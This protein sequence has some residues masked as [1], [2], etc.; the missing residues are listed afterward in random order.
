MA[1]CKF[2]G[3]AAGMFRSEHDECRSLHLNAASK[4][5]QTVVWAFNAPDISTEELRRQV[6]SVA[7]AGFLDVPQCRD[8]IVK[9]W[10][11]AVNTALGEDGLLSDEKSTR[12][13]ALKD[14]LALSDDELDRH[15]AIGRIQKALV[16]E[17]VINGN[18]PDFTRT[19]HLPVNLQKGET[20]VWAYERSEYFEDQ[21]KREY[22]GRSKGV[23][24]Q[25]MKGVR[26]RMGAYK[27]H[28]VD[29]TQRVHVDTGVTVITDRNIYF[30][31]PSKSVRVPYAKIV[32]FITFDDGIGIIRDAQTAKPQMFVTGDGEFTCNLVTNLAQ[33]Q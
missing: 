19:H 32:S 4:I 26:Y 29:K 21:I 31:G 23:S 7:E 24:F 13:M 18:I 5:S 2:C 6:G 14:S 27:G 25:I 3:Q 1:N 11:E 30:A 15:G 10:S 9:G 28:M 20:I 22:V 17:G 8:A 16:L 33:Q 12:L